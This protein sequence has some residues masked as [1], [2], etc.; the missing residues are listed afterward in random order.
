MNKAVIGVSG[1]AIAV[2]L[3]LGGC[4]TSSPT[5]GAG[6]DSGGSE[7]V[8]EPAPGAGNIDC[9]TTV[10]EYLGAG[11]SAAVPDLAAMNQGIE[12][13]I[14]STS[15]AV[16]SA[17]EAVQA[18][19]PEQTDTDLLSDESF[20]AAYNGMAEPLAAACPKE[21]AELSDPKNW[22]PDST[23]DPVK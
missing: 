18:A 15:G 17:A 1:V 8:S 11:F 19:I 16:K 14:A 3:A 5:S 6:D 12:K 10:I 7:E 21:I 23:F 9:K 4:S 22:A 20:L 13:I 2:L